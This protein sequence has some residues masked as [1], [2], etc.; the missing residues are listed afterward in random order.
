MLEATELI[1]IIKELQSISE[2]VYIK[3]LL[4]KVLKTIALKFN[5]EKTIFVFKENDKWFIQKIDKSKK[6]SEL[7]EIKS[8]EL[9]NQ[10]PMIN[11]VITTKD[12]VLDNKTIF[13]NQPVIEEINSKSITC[14]PIISNNNVIALIY[15]EKN[16]EID[17]KDSEILKILSEQISISLK[18]TFIYESMEKNA[19]EK[20]TQLKHLQT[21][22]INSEKMA[23]L[24]A[25]VTNIAHEINNPTNFVSGISLNLI[26]NFND[27]EKFIFDLAGEDADPKFI[28]MFEGHFEQIQ[29]N[30]SDISEGA[31]RI[32]TIV[33][34]LRVFSRLDEAEQKRTN[35]TE[36]IISSI[37][38]IKSKYKKEVEFIC[39]FEAKAQVECW[40]SQINQVF[41]NIMINACQAI[42]EKQQKN[43]LEII[44][45]LYIKTFLVN[46]NN[47]EYLGIEFTDNG[48]GMTEEVKSKIFEPFFTTKDIGN[49]TG[50]GMSI[51]HN[52]INK[53][54]GYI[55][56]KS[57][58]NI[59]STFSVYLPLK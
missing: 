13:T 52:I 24:G 28:E 55:K 9:I 22:M 3:P 4:E 53:H 43:T 33:N 46:E 26:N 2:E 30:L 56:I 23:G 5:S 32:K 31:D 15:L 58:P 44:G 1:S 18:N 38:L 45:K 6:I 47:K 7:E 57:E 35:I 51:S 39:D 20:N 59:G 34:D 29:A 10:Y 19:E 17:N 49:G 11:Q 42:Q 41:M 54:N 12:L 40:A 8:E 48:I 14:Q 21:Q 25:L 37:R 36:G 27:L 50:L 16:R